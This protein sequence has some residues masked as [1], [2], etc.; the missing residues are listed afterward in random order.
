MAVAD[1][2]RVLRALEGPLAEFQIEVVDVE[3]TGAQLQVTLDRPGG[4]DI[5]AIAVATRQVSEILRGLDIL[6]DQDSLEVSSPGIER[7]LRT[8]EHFSR[9]LGSKIAVRL[10]VELDGQR[11]FEGTLAEADETGV[12]VDGHRIAYE[13]IERARTVFE[14]PEAAKR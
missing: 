13:S 7:P 11:R 3:R 4:I 1:K 8:P 6:R 10:R 2:D 5:D 9:A 14:W 12:V